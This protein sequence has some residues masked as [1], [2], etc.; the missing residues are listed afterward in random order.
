MGVSILLRGPHPDSLRVDR[1]KADEC[2]RD[3]KGPERLREELHADDSE[4]Q[5]VVDQIQVVP[6]HLGE[7]LLADREPRSVR[8]S[9][10][11]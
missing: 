3:T 9:R 11:T 7:V 4:C 10:I 1:L 6:A 8:A 5:V 2:R